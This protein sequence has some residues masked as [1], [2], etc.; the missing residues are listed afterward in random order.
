MEFLPR[1]LNLAQPLL[2]GVS[3]N[4]PEDAMVPPKYI[5]KNWGTV[6]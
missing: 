6:L 4:E 3:R 1:N 2:L 5:L